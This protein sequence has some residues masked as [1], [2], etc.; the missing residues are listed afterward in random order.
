M[1]PDEI[2]GALLRAWSRIY[3]LE[4]TLRDLSG[5]LHVWSG[6]VECGLSPYL[7]NITRAQEK[8]CAVLKADER[9]MGDA[10]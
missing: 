2:S 10:A 1:T 4:A 9:L 8:I 6:D 7:G 3:I 5:D